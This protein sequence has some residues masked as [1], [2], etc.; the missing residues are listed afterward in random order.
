MA[1][2]ETPITDIP[3]PPRVQRLWGIDTPT[4]K[5]PRPGLSRDE[6]A[7]SAVAI[8]DEEGLAA[9]SMSRV[10]ESLG[11]TTMSLYR[12]VESKDELIALMWD[13]SLSSPPVLDLA[14]GWRPALERWALLQLRTL[15]QHP[16]ALDIPINNPPL[17][18][19]Q[20]EWMEAGL[21]ALA[22]TPLRADEKLGVILAISVAVLAEGRLTRELAQ[23]D[24]M[25]ANEYGMLLSKLVD[26]STHPNLI[27]AVEEGAFEFETEDPEEDFA[28]S[29]G[30]TL[31]GIEQ[32]IQE[33]T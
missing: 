15:R 19:R 6:I 1:A 20:L 24:D 33:R 29:L 18:P 30:L 14:D 23:G 8:A 2:D 13:T 25:S 3:I 26:E 4:R 17:S 21:A 5:G 27:N 7:A 10:A 31:D 16:W 28:F 11:Y 32:M 22:D 12:Y 9:V